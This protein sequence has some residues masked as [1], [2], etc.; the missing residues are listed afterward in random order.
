MIKGKTDKAIEFLQRYVELHKK[1]KRGFEKNF[2]AKI[3][4]E[5]N[6]DVFTDKEDARYY[7]RR[8]LNQTGNNKVRKDKAEYLREQ[9]AFIAEPIAELNYRPFI[10]PKAYNHAL[11]TAD[12]HGLFYDRK[13][14]DAAINY[15]LKRNCNCCI[16][17]GDFLDCYQ[18]SNLINPIK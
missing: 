2:M 16:I 7:I 5:E 3:L 6:P 18:F 12:W 1:H 8:A 10:V 14:V 9:W 17:D 11:I 4:H 13:A 15:G